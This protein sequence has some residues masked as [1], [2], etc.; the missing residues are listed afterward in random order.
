M[1]VHIP[2]LKRE[3]IEILEPL[4]NENFIDAT[5]GEGGHAIAI[6]EKTSPKGKLLGI[7]KNLA[8]LKIAKK[9]LKEMGFERR[10]IL[11]KGNFKDLKEIVERTGFKEIRG[12]LFDLGISRWHLER[13]KRG[14]SFL[15]D[16]ILDMRF[17]DEEKITAQEIVN[18][19]PQ[20]ELE[21]ILKEYGEERFYKRIVKEILRARKKKPIKTTFELKEIIKRAVPKWYFK[22]RIHPAT[23]TFMALRIATNNEIE[24]LKMGLEAGLEVLDKKGKIGVIS[25]HSIEDRIVKQFFKEKE[26]MG[27]IKILTKKPITPQV[28]EIKANPSSRSAKLRVA[29]KI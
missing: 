6:L 17:G 18:R 25:F 28:K 10:V 7:D 29:M 22:K 21:R 19:Y 26:K 16:E 12:I 11:V 1:N 9:N 20:K 15:R 13:S 24:N 27:E 14:F 3:V 5:I 2:V 4:K 23:K 8:L